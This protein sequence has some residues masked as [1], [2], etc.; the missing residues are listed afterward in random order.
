MHSHRDAHTLPESAE[1]LRMVLPLMSKYKIPV[2]PLNY[3]VWFEYTTGRNRELNER[4]DGC[5]RAGTEINEM[6]T[7]T[8]HRDYIDIHNELGQLEKSRQQLAG[9]HDTV[10]YKLEIACGTTSDFGVTLN[11]YQNRIHT[12]LDSDQLNTLIVDLDIS[13]NQMLINNRHLL[14]ELHASRE[15]VAMLKQQ[16]VE[17]RK[18][19]KTDSLTTLANRKA[20]FDQAE[21]MLGSGKFAEGRHSLFM[22]DIDHFKNVNDTFGHLFGD[23]V[24]RAVAMVLKKNT[25]GKDLAARFGGEEFVVL[26]PDTSIEGARVVAETI[27]S[28]I[29]LASIVNPT[30]KA[31]VSKVTVSIG[32]TEFTDNDPIEA[33][34]HRADRALYE[35]KHRGRNQVAETTT[36]D[37]PVFTGAATAAMD[38]LHMAG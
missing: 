16:L 15:E 13:T 37:C 17:A 1:L 29:D 23:K 18:V 26:L 35:A 12:G 9:L 34:I 31:I 10:A 14:K 36:D 38:K 8:L 32:V 6:L 3:A 30:N 2:T 22:L 21:D 28:T 33:V 19:V 4:L 11:R 25:R 5:I 7:A 24:I 20:F 27:R